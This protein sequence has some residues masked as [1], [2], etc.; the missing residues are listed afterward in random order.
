MLGRFCLTSFPTY[1]TFHTVMGAKASKPKETTVIN[2][3]KFPV[4]LA[5]R[6]KAYAAMRGTSVKQLVIDALER[7]MKEKK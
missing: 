5:R 3:R 2:L 7:I 4:D 6:A 1:D